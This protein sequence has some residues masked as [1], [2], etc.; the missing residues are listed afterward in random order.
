LIDGGA[1][2]N[3]QDNDG[4]TALV[5]ASRYDHKDIIKILTDTII[6]LQ[7]NSIIEEEYDDIF[8]EKEDENLCC[9][10]FE[11][12]KNMVFSPCGHICTCSECSAIV[13]DCPICRKKIDQKIKVYY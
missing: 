6:K 13:N 8:E 4:Q 12:E 11:E 3:L 2:L 5:I 9:I 7:N 10:C 1:D